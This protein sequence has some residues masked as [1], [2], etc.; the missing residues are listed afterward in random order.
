MASEGSF[1]SLR[2]ETF[3]K[4]Y[5]K[6]TMA[7]EHKQQEVTLEKLAAARALGGFGMSFGTTG[8]AR[9]VAKVADGTGS[10][11]QR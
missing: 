6:N 8:E 1:L 5:M 7:E 9:G 10:E 11:K 2:L 3:L 4:L